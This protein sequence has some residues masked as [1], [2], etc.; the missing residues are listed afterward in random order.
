[1]ILLTFRRWLPVAIV[2]TI[3]C[4]LVYVS[5]QQMMRMSANDLPTQLV[6]DAEGKLQKG[7]PAAT[8]VGPT[9]DIG[10]ST[11]PFL[12]VIDDQQKVIASS[13]RLEGKIPV[14]PVGVLDYAKAH[15]AE[16]HVTWEPKP[17]Y[18]YAIAIVP[19]GVAHPMFLVAGQSLWNVEERAA[20]LLWL[21]AGAWLAALL[22]SL[23]AM[24]FFERK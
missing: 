16:H 20:K 5:A 17:G 19:T 13:A 14:P 4:G 10:M 23:L 15:G 2:T 8:I 21:T 1:M 7:V 3:L 24:E 18:R 22:L 11:M 9:V 12:M 6:H